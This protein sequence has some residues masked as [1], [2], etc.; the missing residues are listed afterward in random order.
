LYPELTDNQLNLIISSL[1]E[2]FSETID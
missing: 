2:W 1:Q